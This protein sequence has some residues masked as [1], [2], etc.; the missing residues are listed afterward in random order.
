MTDP[1]DRAKQYEVA[2]ASNDA[3]LKSC[4][5]A[6]FCCG[7]CSFL[8]AYRLFQVVGT[9]CSIIF[10]T[11]T[12]I[13]IIESVT[14]DGIRLI[15][16]VFTVLEGSY[17]VFFC[18]MIIGA[19]FDVERVLK[20][21]AFLDSWVGLGL[22]QLFVALLSYF[23][24]RFYSDIKESDLLDDATQLALEILCYCAMAVGIAFAIFGLAGGKDLRMKKQQEHLAKE[25][26]SVA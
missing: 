20:S 14:N 10:G 1:N 24:V 9:L 25:E 13:S 19:L 6:V 17:V 7:C 5:V 22:F 2:G 21:F 11:L 18:L 12:V 26:K 16:Q 8:R 4:M 23:R 15:D 3:C